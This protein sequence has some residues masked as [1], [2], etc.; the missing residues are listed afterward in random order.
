[1]TPEFVLELQ[2]SILDIRAEVILLAAREESGSDKIIKDASN[3][4]TMDP[5]PL[6][7]EGNAP[8]GI[9]NLSCRENPLKHHF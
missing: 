1:L 6:P 7:A 8:F 9:E 4:F 3:A 5:F 2:D